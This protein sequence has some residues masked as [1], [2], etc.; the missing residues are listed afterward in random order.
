MGKPSDGLPRN[1]GNIPKTIPDTTTAVVE[2][3][4]AHSN[5]IPQLSNL[6]RSLDMLH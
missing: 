5:L 6:H 2:E 1:G 4:L 3:V